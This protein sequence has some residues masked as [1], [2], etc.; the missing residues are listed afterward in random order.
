MSS[1]PLSESVAEE[2]QEILAFVGTIWAVSVASFFVP[3]LQ[4]FGLV[5]RSLSGLIGIPLMPFLHGGL[6][7]LI[8]NT[9]P[10]IVLLTLL[11]GSK[12]KSWE[13]VISIIGL[14]GAL[15]WLFGRNA[16]HVGASGL[17]F[18]LATFLMVSGF[19]EKRIIPM[20][21]AVVVALMYGMSLLFGMIPRFG[22][23]VSWDGHIC[24]AIAGALVAYLLV[25]GGKLGSSERRSI[26]L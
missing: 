20:I 15:L 4:G 12:A 23:S 13:I 1:T 6:G 16:V 26:E 9:I 7:H 24:G 3:W 10:L 5:P 25:N 19:L 21:I 2:F 11:A 17:V 22:S 18:G 8:S 14:N